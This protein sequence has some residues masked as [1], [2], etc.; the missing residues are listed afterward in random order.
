MSKAKK[1]IRDQIDR[2]DYWM[3]V[4]FIFAAGSR[5]YNRQQAA[6]LL[7]SNL[8]LLSMACDGLQKATDGDHSPHA[9]LNSLLNA[10]VPTSGGTLYITHT[11][12]YHCAVA[13][14]AA[15]I[16]RVIYFPTK[17]IEDNSLEAFRAAYVQPEEFRGNLNWMR[18][19]IKT[20]DAMEIFDP[21]R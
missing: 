6:I 13:I 21:E 17:K 20:L 16:K 8:E 5:N 14:S 2:D 11:P 7:G 3:G 15:S 18:D 1:K 12:C 19:H 4:A 10:R 9:E